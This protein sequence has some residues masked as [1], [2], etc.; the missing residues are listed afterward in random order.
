[1]PLVC[2]SD[3]LVFVRKARNIPLEFVKKKSST[4]VADGLSIRLQRWCLR[5]TLPLADHS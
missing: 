1:V 5:V 3:F 4:G 2:R